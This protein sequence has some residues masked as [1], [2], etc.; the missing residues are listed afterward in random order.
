LPPRVLEKKEPKPFAAAPAGAE[1]E[2]KGL[3]SKRG[4]LLDA[5]VVKAPLT[6]A[7]ERALAVVRNS[8]KFLPAVQDGE[9]VAATVKL[10]VVFTE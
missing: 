1:V 5:S 8:W 9:V 7:G 4:E 10:K 2:I 3:V 6:E